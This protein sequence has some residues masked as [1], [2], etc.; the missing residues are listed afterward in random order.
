MYLLVLLLVLVSSL[1][2]ME[3]TQKDGL[4]VPQKLGS[5]QLFK[6]DEG[7]EIV[8]DGESI[9]VKSYDVDPVLKN[10][11]QDNVEE[12][13]KVGSIL[14]N[15]FD[16]GEYSLK[17]KAKIKGGG[18][19][20]GML[21]GWAVRASM[22]SAGAAATTSAVAMASVG[23]TPVAGVAVA[24]QVAGSWG[25]YIATVEGASTAAAILGYAIVWLP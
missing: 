21:L 17:A 7:F 10:L 16:N 6:T 19:L 3:I 14:V 9:K 23:A 22:Y 4:F 18:P 8:K 5:V 12:F 20:T 11:N 1:N 13:G 25:T 15:K 24:A 2:G